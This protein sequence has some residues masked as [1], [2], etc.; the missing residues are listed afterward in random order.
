MTP[1][2][3]ERV[4]RLDDP[5]AESHISADPD[6]QH[7]ADALEAAQ[8]RYS[9]LVAAKAADMLSRLF[10]GAHTAM[11]ELTSSDGI[12]PDVDL[13]AI[14]GD[15]GALLW[16]CDD[17]ND[18][19]DAQA[20]I[21]REQQ[22]GP[23]TLLLA[24]DTQNAIQALL[25]QAAEADCAVVFRR[26]D[27]P[28]V[29]EATSSLLAYPGERHLH[30]LC[31][32][33]VLDE[34][35]RHHG[36]HHGGEPSN[37]GLAVV[38]VEP[39]GGRRGFRLSV[40]EVLAV[41]VGGVPV[42]GVDEHGA[43]W[44][45]RPDAWESLDQGGRLVARTVSIEGITKESAWRDLGRALGLGPYGLGRWKEWAAGQRKVLS[46]RY[47]LDAAVAWARRNCL[48]HEDER[49]ARY[50]VPSTGIS[51]GSADAACRS[52]PGSPAAPGGVLSGWRYIDHSDDVD[53]RCPWSGKP[54]EYDSDE[55]ARCPNGCAASG[56][57]EACSG[58]GDSLGD[59]EGW[60]GRCGSCRW[61]RLLNSRD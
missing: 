31:L 32:P 56:T 24:A 41:E 49:T 60:N 1:A 8:R 27:L 48:A 21:D 2:L 3:P 34:A 29:P 4:R 5:W 45:P 12:G 20:L 37:E 18:H 26:A 15:Q 46:S 51:D 39:D 38:V 6:R 23:P 22:G 53:G 43:G 40:D 57:E 42:V 11:F 54:V 10:P 7:A 59:N 9:M 30:E 14:R 33:A 13:L 16:F 47:D 58:C 52:E 36:G 35:R 50:E 25:L 55:S 17:F 28:A 44:W 19:P 61:D